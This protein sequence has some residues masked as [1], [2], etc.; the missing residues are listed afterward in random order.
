MLIHQEI[1]KILRDYNK[2]LKDI[3]NIEYRDQ[4]YFAI[5]EIKLNERDTIMA[6]D[7][8]N[9]SLGSFLFNI[10]QKLQTHFKLSEIYLNQ[11]EYKSAYIQ[12][13]S[14]LMLMDAGDERSSNKEGSQ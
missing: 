9:K 13:D 12:H 4:I 10:N 3:K 14:I 6:V 8:Y 1:R 7:N 11:K 5:A 2:M